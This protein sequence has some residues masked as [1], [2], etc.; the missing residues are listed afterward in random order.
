M[1]SRRTSR[2]QILVHDL[3]SLWPERIYSPEKT[4]ENTPD[5]Y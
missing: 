1:I 4:S 3:E 2:P 5:K